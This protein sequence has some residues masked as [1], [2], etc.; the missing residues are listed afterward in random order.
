MSLRR[1][2]QYNVDRVEIGVHRNPEFKGHAAYYLNVM[3]DSRRGP[4]WARFLA[5]IAFCDTR[6]RVKG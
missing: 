3:S 2:T 1:Y 4:F 6:L 5:A